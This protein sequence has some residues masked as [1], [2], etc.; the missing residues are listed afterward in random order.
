M[1]KG[2]KT[3]PMAKTLQAYVDEARLTV[4]EVGPDRGEEIL[5]AGDHLVLDVREPEE[6][7]SGHLPGAVNIPRGILE[8]AADHGHP[9]HDERLWDRRRK[10]LCYCGGGFRSVLAA[11][12]LQEMG[13]KEAVSMKGGWTEWSGGGRAVEG[14]TETGASS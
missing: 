8:V 13:F 7:A 3:G 12:T 14:T 6:Y 10:I 2:G 5:A 4:P 11:K 1:A 9:K